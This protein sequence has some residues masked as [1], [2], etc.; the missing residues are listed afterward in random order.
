M[1]DKQPSECWGDWKSPLISRLP[2]AHA[3]VVFCCSVL[4][5]LWT[6]RY[7]LVHRIYMHII[8]PGK[9]WIQRGQTYKDSE[10][11][12]KNGVK[13]EKLKLTKTAT[14]LIKLPGILQGVYCSM[15]WFFPYVVP[16]IN[17]QMAQGVVSHVSTCCP[18]FLL[19][20][21]WCDSQ[22]SNL[23]RSMSCGILSNPTASA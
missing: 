9:A 23:R 2:P 17:P 11:S 20:N 22:M 10:A 5:H 18:W 14:L 3:S 19:P 15:A 4:L 12:E 6:K 8:R 1:T 13:L 7:N 16:W 21:T